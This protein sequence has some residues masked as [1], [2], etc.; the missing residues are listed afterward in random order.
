VT[1]YLSAAPAAAPAAFAAAPAATAAA[2]A[3]LLE[4]LPLPKLRQ[5]GGKF[6]EEVMARLNVATVGELVS[7][8]GGGG[9]FLSWGVK[10][11]CVVGS[12]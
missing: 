11:G 4:P 9:L 5:L 1:T 10:L 12:G 6:G 3:G 2:V 7:A 8:E